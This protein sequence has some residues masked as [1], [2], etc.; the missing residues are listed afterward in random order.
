MTVKVKRSTRNPVDTSQV[1]T[2]EGEPSPSCSCAVLFNCRE[3]SPSRRAR[4]E[5]A[6]ASTSDAVHFL[7]PPTRRLDLVRVT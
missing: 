3:Y 6:T 1:Q 7:A 5:R 2:E 4:K